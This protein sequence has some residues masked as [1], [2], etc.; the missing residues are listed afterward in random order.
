MTNTYTR[1]PPN[2]TANLFKTIYVGVTLWLIGNH[3]IA[4]DRT[5]LKLFF[6]IVQHLRHLRRNEKA[7]TK[8]LILFFILAPKRLQHIS[9]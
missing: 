2:L 9:I 7:T 1:T 4:S 5:G 6:R 8:H 3:Y